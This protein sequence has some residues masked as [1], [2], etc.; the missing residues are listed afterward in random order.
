MLVLT[1]NI[2]LHV[3]KNIYN[4]TSKCM[5]DWKKGFSHFILLLIEKFNGGCIVD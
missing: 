1:M 2:S 3:H 4:I 5:Y